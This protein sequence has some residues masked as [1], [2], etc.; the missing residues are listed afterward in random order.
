MKG[1]MISMNTLTNRFWHIQSLSFTGTGI[2]PTG[3][4]CL[5]HRGQYD[6]KT[7]FSGGDDYIFKGE[8]VASGFIQPQM[9]EMIQKHW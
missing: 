9:L 4:M 6:T 8:M 3:D 1:K 5:E 7:P 2:L